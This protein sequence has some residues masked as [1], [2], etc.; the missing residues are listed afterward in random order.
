VRLYLDDIGFEVVEK[1]A[2]GGR[3]AS[4]LH[5]RA[6]CAAALHSAFREGRLDRK[7]YGEMF[8]SFQ[9]DEEGG[10]YQW[11]PLTQEIVLRV[12]GVYRKAP[13]KTFLR[14]AD[15]IHLASAAEN[16]FKEIYS[17][18]RH[19]LAAAPLFGLKGRNVIAA[20]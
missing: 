16:G 6:E 20:I 11:F 17:N 10:A 13:P 18:D 9:R 2:A 7:E 15:A 14:A 8:D 4:C 5:G 1:L 19:L 12:E 3:I